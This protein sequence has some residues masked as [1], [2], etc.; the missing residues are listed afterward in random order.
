MPYPHTTSQLRHDLSLGA[1][2]VHEDVTM[3]RAARSCP[4]APPA[5]SECVEM[6]STNPRQGS[7][8]SEEAAHHVPISRPLEHW[9]GGALGE[10]DACRLEARR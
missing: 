5:S 7:R 6:K 10:L 8:L 3:I 9:A 4:V 2:H 1:F